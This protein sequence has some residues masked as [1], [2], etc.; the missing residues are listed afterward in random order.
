MAEKAAIVWKEHGALDCWEYVGDDMHAE[1]AL[2]FKQLADTKPDET[3]IFSW[4]VFKSKE[5]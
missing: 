3:V 5:A 4:I 2:S 1:G